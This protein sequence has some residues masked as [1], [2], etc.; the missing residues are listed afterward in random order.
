MAL[1]ARA[2]DETGSSGAHRR[3]YWTV[4]GGGVLTII[5]GSFLTLFGLVIMVAYLH[6]P[7]EIL[8]PLGAT[9]FASS[10]LSFIGGV[11]AFDHDNYALA[12]VGSAM[13]AAVF[14]GGCVIAII[15]G[16]GFW[17]LLLPLGMLGASGVLLV[18][19]SRKM[20]PV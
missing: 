1:V 9:A 4:T 19:A 16:S 13:P 7:N 12:I 6:S 8:I 10:A 20:F 17:R 15:G 14:L 5:G 2:E 11:A 3:A 18:A